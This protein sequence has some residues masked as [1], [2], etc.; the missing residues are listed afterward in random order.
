[1]EIRNWEKRF[2]LPLGR[3]QAKPLAS[4]SLQKGLGELCLSSAV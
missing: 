4:E 1:M 2:F 3:Y